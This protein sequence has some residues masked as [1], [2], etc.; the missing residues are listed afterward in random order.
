MAEADEN[1]ISNGICLLSKPKILL[2]E[3]LN[4]PDT[5]SISQQNGLKKVIRVG[6]ATILAPSTDEDMSHIM[7]S[8]T[9]YLAQFGSLF[10]YLLKASK[11][12]LCLTW[13]L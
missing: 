8:V 13:A 2:L 6:L 4:A 12:D 3:A 1:V 5:V 9:F 11:Y 10:P 7:Y